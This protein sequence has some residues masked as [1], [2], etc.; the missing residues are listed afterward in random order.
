MTDPTP[1]THAA[2]GT[3][4]PSPGLS[5]PAK[6]TATLVVVGILA[7]LLM[8]ALDNF[9]VLTALPKIVTDLGQPNGVTFVVSSYLISSTV[10]IPI[11]GKLSDLF[12][13]RN[14]FLLGLGIFIAG[15]LASG[16][17]QNLN[18]LIFFRAVQG[19]G[20][21][22]FFPV[23]ISIIAVIFPPE[24][25]ARLIGLLSGVFGIA[26][27][28]GPLLGS[29]IVDNASWRW[30]F[31]VNI[32]V[33]I[34]GLIILLVTLGP[35]HPTEKRTF[36]VPGAALLAGWVG[37]L[38]YALIQVSDSGWAWTDPRIVALLIA[39]VVLFAG[40]VV[41]EIRAKEPLVPLRLFG[42]RVV[43]GSGGT[44]FLVG[45]AVFSL[46]TFISVLVGLVLLTPG[47]S[48]A[49]VVRDVLY[50]LVVPI[51]FG[52]AL[53]GQLLTKFSYRNVTA[54]GALISACGFVFLAAISATTPV[55][56]LKYGFLPVGGIVL[57]LI[58]IG[59]GAGLT[60]PVFI[61][62]VQNEVPTADVGAAS[63]LV[64]FL[65]SLG[66]SMGVSLLAVF[67]QW[68]FNT[69]APAIPAGGCSPSAPPSA[70]CVSYYQSELSA[71]VHSY[72][73]LFTLMLVLLVATFFV[74]F[75]LVGRLP[76][77]KGP[78]TAPPAT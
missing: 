31:Y 67:Q 77:G 26:T 1:V 21:G 58:P 35:L 29:Y 11:F 66:A 72:D 30:V 18:E 62:A 43:A 57:P 34:L 65:Q 78:G 53:G 48:S 13:R 75:L 51:V 47:A 52:A 60:L 17:S 5:T 8:G 25:R 55:W 74:S 40:F 71:L 4:A 54:L 3:T 37:A 15:S 56:V 61:L 45:F 19:F 9:V 6:A 70:A 38:M 23:G 27:V 10:A 33:G 76:T 22:D 14:V 44:A 68:R 73:Q 2:V 7:A 16:L 64:Q 12:S 41:W 36:D 63:G 49:D 46:S 42:R 24:T 50:A 69:A 59:F 20:N 28:A 39:T 32:P